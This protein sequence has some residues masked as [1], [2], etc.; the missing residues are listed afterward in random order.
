MFDTLASSLLELVALT[1]EWLVRTQPSEELRSW[2]DRGES[3]YSLLLCAL[4]LN[5]QLLDNL[6]QRFDLIQLFYCFRGAVR[7]REE[8]AASSMLYCYPVLRHMLWIFAQQ[9][10][11]DS[12]SFVDPGRANLVQLQ[13][14]KLFASLLRSRYVLFCY[15]KVDSREA[16]PVWRSCPSCCI[17]CACRKGCRGS[18]WRT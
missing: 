1:L 11:I 13:T 3:D 14:V 18:S 10:F 4:C 6:S 17:R 9:A 15:N 2:I 16:M 7:D 12:A 8:S 5:P